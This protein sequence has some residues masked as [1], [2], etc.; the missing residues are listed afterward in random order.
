MLTVDNTFRCL[1][2]EGLIT[3]DAV[4][5]GD[6]EISSATRRN[7]NLKVT[8]RGS[9]NYLIKQPSDPHSFADETLRREALFYTF[10]QTEPAVAGALPF[11]PRLVRA[12]PGQ[13]LLILELLRGAKPLWQHYEESAGAVFPVAPAAA[14][15]RALATLHR[16]FA[17]PDV[18][19]HPHLAFLNASPPWALEIHRPTPDALSYLSGGQLHLIRSLQG[20]PRVT[21]SL[22]GLRKAWTPETAVH[23]DVKMDNF[24]IVPPGESDQ[25]PALYLVDW[26]LAQRGDPAWDLGSA[27]ADFLSLW[28]VSM[29]PDAPLAQMA[30]G[31]RRP[32]GTM[33]PAIHALW[34]A[35]G[36]GRGLTPRAAGALLRRTVRYSAARAM[37]TAFEMA[38]QAPVM[39]PPAVLLLQ[40]AVN[41]LKEPVNAL[42]VLYGL[43]AEGDPV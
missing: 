2:A 30:K 22:D 34:A 37:Q 29:D 33:Q 8:T 26:E 13:S 1:Q 35:Y 7:R 15:G 41:L 9:A 42:Q 3:A 12:D 32:I 40:V 27:F 43:T 25:E 24:V 10:C 36:A 23:G 38:K 6:L 14:V 16:L 31:A 19:A 4:V 18:L 11:L 20:Q 39:P 5:D 28:V 21:R 17:A